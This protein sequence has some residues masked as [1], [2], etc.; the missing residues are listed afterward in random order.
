ME[1]ITVIMSVIGVL[2]LVGSCF[3][4]GKTAPE[5]DYDELFRRMAKRELT[6][7]EVERLRQTV[8]RII[9]EKT[10]EVIEKTDDYL[11]QVANEKIM[12]VDEFSKQIFE[13]LDKNN[14]DVVFLYNMLAETKEEVKTVIADAGKVRESLQAETEKAVKSMEAVAVA[15]PLPVARQ[16]KKQTA[17]KKSAGKAPAEKEPAEKAPVEK[18]P[19]RKTTPPANITV[20]PE[21]TVAPG[22]ENGPDADLPKGKIL[23]LHKKGKTVR[24]ISRE[25]GMGQGEVKLVI[26]LYGA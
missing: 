11:S 8:D 25:L 20:L 3:L 18:K 10:E 24:E 16:T 9:S 15:E 22:Q 26:D 6:Q 4:P 12:S 5:T 23:E 13:R 14:S 17:A 1:P 21:L 19:A 7:E 2:L